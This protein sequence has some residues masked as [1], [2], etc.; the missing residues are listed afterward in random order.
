MSNPKMRIP[1]IP[2]EV[3]TYTFTL[4]LPGLIS[5]GG[6]AV[7]ALTGFFIMGILI[8]R[9]YQPEEDMPELVRIM[10]SPQEEVADS[11]GPDTGILK[12]EELQFTEELTRS[13]EEVNATVPETAQADAAAQDEDSEAGKVEVPKQAVKP[14]AA[15]PAV[16]KPKARKPGDQVFDY[17]YQVASFKEEAMADA[18]IAKLA[19]AG[20]KADKESVQAGNATWHRVLVLFQGTPDET[21]VLKEALQ[22]FKIKKPLM[23]SKKPVE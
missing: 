4:T 11:S 10:P 15:K 9:G 8:G 7:L 1:K 12:P 20:F 6:I 2:G 17:V 5:V 23:R 16:L 22:E 14:E 18:F 21:D 19:Q 3:K 13:A